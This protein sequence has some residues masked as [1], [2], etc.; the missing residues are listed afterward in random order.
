M[1]ELLYIL[2]R[3]LAIGILI[4]APMGPIGMLIIQR[5]LSKGRWPAFFTGIGAAFSDLVYCLL[6]GF[7]LSFI[8]GFIDTHQLLIQI[9]GS[10]VLAAF[11]IYLFTKN[12]TRALKT[13]I[14]AAK[15][16][17]GDIVSGFFL[18]FSNPLILF[19]IIGLFARFNIILPE[20]LTYHYIWA[21]LT[22]LAGALLW[23]Y[24][25]TSLVSYLGR[26][27]NVRS[28]R[29]I[30]RIIAIILIVMAIAGLVMALLDKQLM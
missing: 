6:T 11:G 29:I 16:Y 14:P 3:G 26:R 30:N 10:A 2:P 9:V 5:T 4:S 23:W 17:W 20:F 19:F 8:T 24:G 13:P 12:P 27:I 7:C 22:I 25:V 18:T 15:N 1:E 21:Y 28:L